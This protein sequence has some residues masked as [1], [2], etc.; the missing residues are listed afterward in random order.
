MLFARI[1][2]QFGFSAAMVGWWGFVRRERSARLDGKELRG[3]WL[4]YAFPYAEI[5][6]TFGLCHPK[7]SVRESAA[8]FVVF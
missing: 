1:T 7:T 2:L 3:A 4:F 6:K 5:K 8:T